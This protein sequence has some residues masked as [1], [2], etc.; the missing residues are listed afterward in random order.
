M[1]R[2]EFIAALGGAA[3][4]MPALYWPN[5]ARAQQAIPVI[6]FLSSRA[7]E[8]SAHLVAAFR[9]GLAEQNYTERKNVAV[10]YRWARGQWDR[11]PAMA[12]ELVVHNVAVIVAAGGEPAAFAA[13]AATNTIPIVFGS[14]GDPVKNGMVA[15]L[16][17]PGGNVTG[18]SLMTTD[19]EAKRLSFLR[20]AAPR[21]ALTAVLFNPKFPD[22]DARLTEVETAA[23]QLNMSVQILRTST[24]ADMDIALSAVVEQHAEALLVTG[25]PFFD[26]Q[27]TKIIAFTKQH[28]VPAIYQFREYAVAGGLMTYGPSIL[29]NYRQF[30]IY[31]GRI[32]KGSKPADMPIFRSVKFELVINL[33]T[34]KSLDLN[35]PPTLLALADEVIE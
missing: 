17:R 25:D 20:A 18:T 28:A 24:E 21:A 10:D 31:T 33:K 34:A 11:L 9:Q 22:A 8:D 16:N 13:K 1:K 4:G 6:G 14:G 19:V 30:G 32:L 26:T 3:A 23:R 35:M 29:D 12:A 27:R 5:V 7:P 2:R 15:S